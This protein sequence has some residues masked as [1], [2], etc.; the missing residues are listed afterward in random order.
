MQRHK[1]IAWGRKT[2]MT[3]NW[4]FLDFA[5]WRVDIFWKKKNTTYILSQ[6]AYGRYNTPIYL[7]QQQLLSTC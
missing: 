3:F 1:R 4:L 6:R 2:K 7:N 5:R